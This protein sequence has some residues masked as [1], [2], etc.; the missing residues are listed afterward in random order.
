MAIRT[1]ACESMT[2]RTS[3]LI[4]NYLA[5]VDKHNPEEVLKGIEEY[6]VECSIVKVYASEML[7]YV[8]DEAVQIFGGYGYSE[9]Y[10]VAR[11]YRDARINRIFEGTNEINR[12]L[13]TG[14]LLKR[15][16]KGDLPLMQ[17]G[18]K[19]MDEIMSFPSFDEE[20]DSL[21]ST[22][23]KL[24]INSKKA[25]LLVSGAAI[26]KYMAKIN[27]EQELMANIADVMMEVYAMESAVLRTLKIA[28]S[29]GE[30]DSETQLHV[31]ATRVFI[32]DAVSRVNLLCKNVLATVSEGDTLRTQLAALRR[33]TKNTPI[34][35]VE[36]RRSIADRVIEAGTYNF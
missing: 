30:N 7:A 24:V 21:L 26:Q 28:G 16:M 15:A 5:S 1:Y 20:E 32:N 2:Y 6:A 13:I 12:M 33:F 4:D 31:D 14:M 36:L 29:K 18:M 27:D 19:I 23:K 17:A 8:V 35:T 10:P 9:E 11:F 25:C 3:G 22:E 34:N